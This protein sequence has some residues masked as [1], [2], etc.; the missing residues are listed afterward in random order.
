MFHAGRD[1]L[2]VDAFRRALAVNPRSSRRASTWR[3]CCS[4]RRELSLALE[5]YRQ[6]LR[7]ELS[8]RRHG[9]AW[10]W[11]CAEMKQFED[12]RNAFGRAID[13]RPGT[14]KRTLPRFPLSN[15][16][17]FNG[18]LRETKRALELDPWLRRASSSWPSTWSTKIRG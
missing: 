17:D 11:C 10:A 3:C 16:G 9:T 5:A 18:A 2:A 7:L 13:S 12:A 15:L 6:V 14:P 1:D 8:I 4:K